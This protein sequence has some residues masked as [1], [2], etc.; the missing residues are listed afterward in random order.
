MLK[1]ENDFGAIFFGGQIY[2]SAYGSVAALRVE[3]IFFF[4]NKRFK[5]CVFLLGA[6]LSGAPCRKLPDLSK[7]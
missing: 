2:F 7:H 5:S 4:K 3:F 1:M 6:G